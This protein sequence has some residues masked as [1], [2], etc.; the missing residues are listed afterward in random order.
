MYKLFLS[1]V[2]VVSLNA[3]LI[4]GLAIVVKGQGITL[5]DI[6]KE[7]QLSHIDAKIASDVL[8][9]KKLELSEILEKRITVSSSDVYDEINKMAQR[10][11][12]TINQFYEAVRNSSGISSTQLKRKIRERLLSQKLYASIAYSSV[13]KP[14]AS[15]ILDYYNLHKSQFSHP[16][17]FDVVVYTSTNQN[18]LEQKKQNFMFYSP[19][20]STQDKTFVYD[21]ISLQLA[22]LLNNT[23]LNHFTKTMP[24]GQGQYVSFY[25]KNT[26]GIKTTPL[27]SASNQIS[28]QIMSQQ[29]EQVLSDYFNRLRVNAD[30]KILREVN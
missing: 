6:K 15:D 14:S 7:M 27:S 9:R 18:L 8:I 19:K 29:R 12:L 3:E 17:S 22:K 11:K 1:L 24:N 20:I 25:I 10:S 13:S 30:I 4:D 28:N 5:L 2:F 21:E 23:K 16:N 26:K